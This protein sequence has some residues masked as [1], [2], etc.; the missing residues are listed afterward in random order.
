[1]NAKVFDLFVESKMTMREGLIRVLEQKVD[2]TILKREGVGQTELAE[3]EQNYNG[4][5]GGNLT[6]RDEGSISHPFSGVS[7]EPST[8]N[9]RPDSIAL[10]R[11]SR[12]T[13]PVLKQ[14]SY[15]GQNQANY[16]QKQF[17][18]TDISNALGMSNE[19]KTMSRV[20][21][22]LRRI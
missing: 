16:P 11:S 15:A 20:M 2:T 18:V 3:T 7:K 1:M 13:T 14:D 4:Y 9:N 21:L 17:T 5:D 6:L 22:E 19:E 12:Q 10:R 8:L